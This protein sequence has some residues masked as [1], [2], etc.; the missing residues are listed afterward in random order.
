M[1]SLGGSFHPKLTMSL[2]WHNRFFL[3]R[4]IPREIEISECPPWR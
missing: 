2:I 4:I 3:D 1:Q